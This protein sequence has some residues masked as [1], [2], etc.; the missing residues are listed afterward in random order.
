MPKVHF[1]KLAQELVTRPVLLQKILAANGIAVQ[2]TS[3]MLDEETALIVR[4]FIRHLD[5]ITKGLLFDNDNFLLLIYLI[6]LESIH[7]IFREC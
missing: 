7:I 4:N 5:T 1:F 3:S 2:S 6:F